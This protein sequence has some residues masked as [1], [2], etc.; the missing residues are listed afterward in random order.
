MSRIVRISTSETMM[1][2]GALLFRTAIFMATRPDRASHQRRA[3][4]HGRTNGAPFLAA[5][6]AVVTLGNQ[7]G[8]D[9]FHLN[10][11]HFDFLRKI[12]EGDQARHRDREAENGAVK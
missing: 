1:M 6:P 4:R 12:A 10:R 11:E 7:V 9:R 2:E 3:R 5:G 8:D